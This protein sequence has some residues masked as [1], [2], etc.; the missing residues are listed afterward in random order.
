MLAISYEGITDREAFT[1]Q[2]WGKLV[3]SSLRLTRLPRNCREHCSLLTVF[4]CFR[5]SFDSIFFFFSTGQFNT[6][7]NRFEI[8][9]NKR[10]PADPQTSRDFPDLLAD[11]TERIKCFS[12]S[13]RMCFAPPILAWL[14]RTLPAACKSSPQDSLRAAQL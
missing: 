7:R 1:E 5:P 9:Q 6:T 11:K 2:R 8:S 14:L 10:R 12:V 3:P 13:G 4:R